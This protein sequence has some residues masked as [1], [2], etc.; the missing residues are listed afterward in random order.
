MLI[1]VMNIHFYFVSVVQINVHAEIEY[2]SSNVTV[3]KYDQVWELLTHQT[4]FQ[5]HLNK[6][7]GRYL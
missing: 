5:N 6:I 2:Q 3:G 1:Y 4:P 7:M